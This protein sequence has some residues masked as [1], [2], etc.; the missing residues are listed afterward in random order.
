MSFYNTLRKIAL[1]I[2]ISMVSC[3][4]LAAGLDVKNSE[5]AGLWRGKVVY[6]V[7]NFRYKDPLYI[8][9]GWL[10]MSIDSTGKLLGKS[11]NECFV[12]GQV[13]GSA[14]KTGY[15]INISLYKC[16][17]PDLNRRYKG[18]FYKNGSLSLSW[19][20][21]DGNFPIVSSMDAKLY[22]DNN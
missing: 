11:D 6:T 1:V 3:N 22:R 21:K 16:P 4:L 7:K 10:V 18:I 13:L 12:E 19:E 9:D 5:A 20:M 2:S 17:S 14:G 15:R 8:Y